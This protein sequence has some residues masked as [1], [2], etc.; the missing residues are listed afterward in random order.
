[1]TTQTPGEKPIVSAPC[2][3]MA[4]EL[5]S[6]TW[7]LAFSDGS[8]RRCRRRSVEAR[9]VAGLLTEI[10]LAKEKLD[11]AADATVK[12]V[13]EAGRDG[14]WIDR[15]MKQ[16]GIENVVIDPTSLEVDRRARRAKTDRLDVERLLAS[17][18]RHHRGEKVWRVVRVPTQDEEDARRRHR[19]RETLVHESTALNNRA[20][21]LMVLQGIEIRSM[22][23]LAS[24]L[25][26]LRCWDGKPL[27]TAMRD[28]L[29][30]LCERWEV[31]HR[32]VLELEAVIR[33]ELRES[34]SP[35]VEQARTLQI[36][37]GISPQSALL[38]SKE[39]FSWRQIRNRR[40]LGALAGLVASPYSSGESDRQRGIT[41]AGNRRVRVLMVE[42]AWGWLRY[43]PNSKL[44]MW[45][46]DH[47]SGG[48][49]TK[50]VGIVALARKLLVA[51]WRLIQD[52]VV[53]E[54]AETRPV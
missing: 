28:E 34:S 11:L 33:D 5:S 41:K 37:R 44:T 48:K 10:R 31:V 7:G 17:L 35:A 22:S 40:Q 53:P 54:G 12:C 4:M 43:Q 9:D 23:G 47:F 15:A 49:R 18:V 24:K 3:Y 16:H 8:A 38:L 19:E 21:G 26:S 36:L 45:F 1:M 25:D 51:F 14:F 39:M 42:L 50:R 6:K 30:R 20:R 13:F 27:P 46:N 29:K 32:Q 52:G 2:L